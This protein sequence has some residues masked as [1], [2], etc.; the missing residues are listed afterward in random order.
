VVRAEISEG[1]ILPQA[2]LDE[3]GTSKDGAVLLFLGV[4]R[5][6]HEGRAVKGLDY[7]AYREMAEGILLTIGEEARRTFGVEGIS[8]VHRVGSL[9]VGEVSLAVVV[10]APHRAEAYE[11]SRFVLESIKE[12][13]PVWKKE[14]YSTGPARWVDG[15]TPTVPASGPGGESHERETP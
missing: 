7:E 14:H 8:M 4:V 6:R 12:R 15:R 11:A 10:A 13:L 2:I 3:V 9:T 5:D 1:P